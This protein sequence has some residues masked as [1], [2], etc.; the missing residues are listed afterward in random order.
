M[1]TAENPLIEPGSAVQT[2]GASSELIPRIDRANRTDDY[3]ILFGHSL[4]GLF[5]LYS[6]ADPASPFRA[7]LAIAPTLDW[8]NRWALRQA[9]AGFGG[10]RS[11]QAFLYVARGDDLGQALADF[12]GFVAAVRKHAAPELRV[13]A[14]AFPDE[15]HV[16]IPLITA[17]DSLRQLYAG[18]RLHP[19]DADKGLVY[20]DEH[21]ANVSKRMGVTLP[22][23]EIVVTEM[24]YG[25]L[26]RD[27]VDEAI[28]VFERNVQQFPQSANAADSLADGYVA[29]RLHVTTSGSDRSGFLKQSGI[30]ID[31]FRKPLVRG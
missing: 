22:V 24:G 28:A 30:E 14:A 3:R 19:D 23:P 26:G 10:K 13:H 2:T 6:A 5:A 11:A 1:T 29:S 21:F 27:K 31:H 17:I 8:D 16:T 9:E 25:L 12:D 20:A 4:G 7:H 15:M 18:Y